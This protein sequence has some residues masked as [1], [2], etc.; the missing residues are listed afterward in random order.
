M[1]LRLV[2]KITS[3]LKLPV[4]SYKFSV[5]AIR[6]RP[7]KEF[8]NCFFVLTKFSISD[9]ILIIIIPIREERGLVCMYFVFDI[10]FGGTEAG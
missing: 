9:T 3:F 4:N 1:I 8:V 7:R 10:V 5:V 6:L 2:I